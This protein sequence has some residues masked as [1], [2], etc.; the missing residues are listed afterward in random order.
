[1]DLVPLREA[2]TAITNWMELS[3]W[4]AALALATYWISSSSSAGI[5]HS[6]EVHRAG[7]IRGGIDFSHQADGF[8]PKKEG[9]DF[10]R[11]VDRSSAAQETLITVMKRIE[12]AAELKISQKCFQLQLTDS[13]N[14][15]LTTAL[16]NLKIDF[17]KGCT[18]V[19]GLSGLYYSSFHIAWWQA[20]QRSPLFQFVGVSTL[21]ILVTILT[22]KECYGKF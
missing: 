16:R 17:R 7:P 21:F 4:G 22:F 10:D 18:S 6:Q 5:G 2:L 15:K 13:E 1:M 12:R 19:L 11:G 20:A 9:I 8:R 3:P 14:F